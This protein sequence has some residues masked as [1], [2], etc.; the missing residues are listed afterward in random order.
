MRNGSLYITFEK[1]V[2]S[3]SNV[4][5]LKA[6]NVLQQGCFSCI[7]LLQI[8]WTFWSQIFKGFILC[9]MFRYTKW[10][11]RSWHLPKVYSAFN[12]KLTHAYKWREN[13]LQLSLR[14]SPP[15]VIKCHDLR[16]RFIGNMNYGYKRLPQS[17]S[18]KNSRSVYNL[19]STGPSLVPP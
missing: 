5:H 12:G 16:L 13:P 15:T 7:V 18:A 6:H 19:F 2:I 14:S 11:Y 8:R 17:L 3:R 10:E 9:I 1:E 4:M